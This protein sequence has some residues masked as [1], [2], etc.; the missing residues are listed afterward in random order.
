MSGDVFGNGMLREKTTKLVAAFDHRDIF[1]DPD[2]DA[3]RSFAERKRMFDLPRSSW[4]DFDKALISKGGG[5]YPRSA[6][7]IRLS[8][9]AQKLFGVGEH[10]T[11]QELIRAILK[12]PVD[13]LFFGG[14]G[15]YVRAAD[16]TDEAVGDRA[17]DAVRVAGKDLRCKV[18]G[19]GAN[20]GM[21]QRGRIEAAFR[22]IRLNT[23]A[24]DNSA[25]VNTSDMEVNIKIA[26][27]IP[28]AR[29]PSHD[30]RAQRAPGRDDRRSRRV[31]CCATI[32]C[33]RWRC[34]LP[35]AAA[36][37]ISAS[38]SA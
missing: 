13:L 11:P 6:K 23:D 27:S 22:G 20:L 15:T 37:R 12:A 17:N 3:E 38:C 18:I 25:G 19:E 34:R 26:L 33:S 30:G 4:Q 29:R 7:D 14:I 10:L 1:I 24:I 8:P 28:R 16:E 32:I 2:P 36:W 5:V 31:W 35:S 21:T 9:E